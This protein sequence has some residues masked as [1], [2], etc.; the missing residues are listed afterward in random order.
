MCAPTPTPIL[1]SAPSHFSQFGSGT[2]LP[3]GYP[4]M[5][6]VPGLQRTSSNPLD[7]QGSGRTSPSAGFPRGTKQY[8]RAQGEGFKEEGFEVRVGDPPRHV[9]P[10]MCHWLGFA[11]A[12]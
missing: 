2:C 1:T 8:V 6:A 9:S 4:E 10:D 7:Q 5:V 12:R 11:A 3:V